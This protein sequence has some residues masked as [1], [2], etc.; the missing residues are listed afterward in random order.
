MKLVT[1]EKVIPIV[2]IILDIGAA[3]VYAYCHDWKKAV[4]WV[5]AATLT[6]CVTF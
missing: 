3:G 4:Y 2:L 6:A 5:A 1:F